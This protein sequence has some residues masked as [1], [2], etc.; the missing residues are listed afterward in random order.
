[1]S[2]IKCINCWSDIS[3][4]ASTCPFCRSD[5]WQLNQRPSGPSGPGLLDDVFVGLRNLVF[6]DPDAP[7]KLKKNEAFGPLEEVGSPGHT[8]PRRVCSKCRGL[9]WPS[10]TKC[11]DCGRMFVA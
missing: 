9:S 11:H 4:M 10:A 6:G 5:P 1:M 8:A 7:R 3:P 2:T